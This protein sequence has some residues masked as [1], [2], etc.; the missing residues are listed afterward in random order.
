MKRYFVETQDYNFVAFTDDK[1]K[2]F[3]MVDEQ[4]FDEKLTLEVAKAADY[5]T[6]EDFED[7]EGANANYSDGNN[8]INESFEDYVENNDVKYCE[9]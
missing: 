7:I 9:F 6:I 2:G 3:L 8:L 1:N 5:S 4:A